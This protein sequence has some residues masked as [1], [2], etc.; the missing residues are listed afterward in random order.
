MKSPLDAYAHLLGV[1]PDKEI[2][3]AAGT[4]LNNVRA[5]RFRRG[6]R[7]APSRETGG[8]HAVPTSV[9]SQILAW[10]RQ[11]GTGRS[12]DVADA[13]L[14]QVAG[15]KRRDILSQTTRLAK[16]G[17]LLRLSHGTYTIN[18]NTMETP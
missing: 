9:R 7:I 6:I 2:A 4:N 1:V 10:F 17:K 14:P 13:L 5:Y 11:H 12:Q 3:A 15:N 8:R 16:E 18:T